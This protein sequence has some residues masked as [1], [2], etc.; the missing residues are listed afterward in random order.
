MDRLA[1]RFQLLSASQRHQ[2]ALD[3]LLQQ[4][5]VLGADPRLWVLLS[6]A[7]LQT[8][9]WQ[10]AEQ[11]ARSALN[12]EPGS[13]DGL[14]C[15]GAALG[16]QRRIGEALEAAYAAK[17]Q[18]PGDAEIYSLLAQLH[19]RGGSRQE[20]EQALACILEALH[21]RPSGD[22]FAVAALVYTQLFRHEEARAV[23]RDGLAFDPDNRQLQLASGTVSMGGQVAGQWP[24]LLASL[25]ARSPMDTEAQAELRLSALSKLR[26]LAYLPWLQAMVFCWLA[27]VLSIYLE[28][29]FPASAGRV[30]LPVIAGTAVLLTVLQVVLS[31]RWLVRVS[32]T[33]PPGYLRGE[34]SASRPARSSLYALVLAEAWAAG[35]TLW[36]ALAPGGP[37]QFWA[38]LALQGTTALSLA[39]VYLMDRA[40]VESMDGFTPQRRTDFAVRR[41]AVAR[42][43]RD[44]SKLPLLFGVLASLLA[45]LQAGEPAFG[46]AALVSAGAVLLAFTLEAEILRV[47]LFLA[48]SGSPAAAPHPSLGP[49][50]VLLWTVRILRVAL[51]LGMLCGGVVILAGNYPG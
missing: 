38:V 43:R 28:D 15:L 19:L 3:L 37:P 24:G 34:L 47:R 48:R 40:A 31:L 27:P 45:W 9:R 5:Q 22:D 13:R 12:L 41:W 20:H 44:I 1:V 35:A 11:A 36:A 32:K 18:Y 8:G 33:Y 4:V 25:L 6:A 17:A 10:E 2:E 23:L 21:L 7:F 30:R 16:S 26:N 51:P 39:G 42:Q 50:S 49:S 14:V 29:L 46:G